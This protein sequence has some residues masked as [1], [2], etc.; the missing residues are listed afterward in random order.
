VLLDTLLS[1][2]CDI[3]DVMLP[4][5]TWVEKSG[6]FEN[7]RN[8]LQAFEQAIPPIEACKSEGQLVLDM[9]AVLDGREV[10]DEAVKPMVLETTRGQVAAGVQVAVP[11][12]PVYNAADT[13][14]E[15]ARTFSPLNVFDTEVAMA[16]S[17]PSPQSA[18][19]MVEI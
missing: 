9:Q 10:P 7:A 2:L 11:F 12:G 13:R 17:E 14:R 5:A 19:A 16:P 15:M 6:T 18:M 3:A 4:G 8:M 1:P